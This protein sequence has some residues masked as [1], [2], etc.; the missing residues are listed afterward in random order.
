MLLTYLLTYS[1]MS[2]LEHADELA[3]DLKRLN[4][5]HVDGWVLTNLKNVPNLEKPTRSN[6]RCQ[7]AIE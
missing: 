6:K 5:E 1:R 2:N 4:L 7:K 3:N